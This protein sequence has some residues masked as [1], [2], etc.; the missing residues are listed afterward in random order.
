MSDEEGFDDF[1]SIEWSS[2]TVWERK[3][4]GQKMLTVSSYCDIEAG[5]DVVVIREPVFNEIREVLDI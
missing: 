5:E 1:K 4:N 2:G 3:A